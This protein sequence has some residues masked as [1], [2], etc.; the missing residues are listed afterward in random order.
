MADQTNLFAGTEP[1]PGGD[2][3]NRVDSLRREIN[4]HNYLYHVMDQPEISDAEYDR[5]LREL[6]ELEQQ[7]PRLITPDSPTQRVGAE[8]QAQFG[9][10]EHRQQMLSLSNA[11]SED[12]LRAFDARV[13]RFL[14]L[15]ESESIEYVAEPKIDGLAVSLTYV[16]GLFTVGATRGDGVRGEN[17]TA[18][19]RTIKSL[20]LN[21]N[22]ALEMDEFPMPSF[23]EVRGEVYL[24]HQEFS[25]IND[26]RAVNGEP[27]FAN[28]RNAA[29]GSVRQLDPSVTAKRNLNLF[30]YAIGE[31]EGVSLASQYDLLKALRDWRFRT[32]PEIRLCSGIDGVWEFVSEFEG[33]RE[34][35]HYDVDGV[36]VKV[37]SREYEDR[38]GS[39]ARSPRWAIAFKF[40]PT[41][42]ITVVR[43]MFVSV[44][45]TGALTPVVCMEP[46]EVGGVTVSRA[47][48]HN[49]DEVRRKDVRIG[50]T[51]VIQRA[52]DVIPEVVEVVKGKRDGSEMEF[53][54]PGKCPV[55]G[56][57]TERLPGEAVT[58]CVG[59]ACSAQL[60]E[61]MWHFASRSA[62]DIEHVGPQLVEQ[63]LEKGLISDPADLYSLTLEQLTSLDRM[64]VK[65]AQNVLDAIQRS[66]DTS[67][68]RLIFAMGIRHVGERTAEVL[69]AHFRS[70]EAIGRASVEELSA[71]SDV[72]PVVAES[73]HKFFQQD[74]TKMV[75]GKLREAGVKPREIAVPAAAVQGPLAGKKFVFTGELQTLTRGE[76]EAKARALGASAASSVSKNT[77]Y[78]VAGEKAGSKLA[79]AREL[80]VTVLTEEEF[81]RM[82][83]EV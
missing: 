76:A 44:G 45:R 5:L 55:C 49:E 66:K 56:A 46:V 24:E 7:Y 31:I 18:N 72:G 79:K 15:P 83:N 23:V 57:D 63:L 80:G 30:T 12:E 53:V 28:P 77:D 78:V 82:S 40:A 58:R 60:R 27:T 71:V 16:N 47:T 81:L 62:M 1:D 59:I 3:R 2:I 17:I 42:A 73:I 13:R 65:S 33:K 43:D 52:G 26:E 67:L 37:N 25:R 4:R 35:L 10:H 19:L 11:F 51:V 70:L 74:E 38:L 29:A 50:D 20:P 36:V 69:A 22:H 32:N 64:G 14:D 61:R 68:A 39:V 8:P 75:L 41:Q 54:M 34:S 6:I 48:M 9:T 21:L